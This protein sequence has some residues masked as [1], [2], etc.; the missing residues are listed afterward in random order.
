MSNP[1]DHGVRVFCRLGSSPV[2]VL[3]VPKAH[4][5]RQNVAIVGLEIKL[6]SRDWNLSQV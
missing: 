4:I 2:L 1:C 6:L 3:E 5:R